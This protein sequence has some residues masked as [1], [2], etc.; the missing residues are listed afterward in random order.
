M[1]LK[2]AIGFGVLVLG[3]VFCAAEVAQAAQSLLAQDAATASIFSHVVG[4]FFMQQRAFHRGL[5]RALS[6]LNGAGDVR[7]GLWLIAVGFVYG[8]FHAAGPGHGKAVLSA[9]LLTNRVHLRRGAVLAVAA[10][11]CQGLSA[12]SIVYGLVWLAGWRSSETMS[13]VSWSERLSYTLLAA[14]GAFWTFRAGRGL[15][16][17]LRPAE[18][19]R[20]GDRE[21]HDHGHMHDRHEHD[22]AHGCGCCHAPSAAQVE[23]AGSLRAAVVLILSIGLRPC[24]G[25]VLILVFAYAAHIPWAGVSAVI[26]MSSGTALTVCTLAVLAVKAR[27]WADALA[28]E[29][30]HPFLP[31]A[32]D[33]FALCCGVLVFA[34]GA[35]MLAGSFAPRLSSGIL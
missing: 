8:V 14:M 23:G 35:S 28:G 21:E 6:L 7:A 29:R 32:M 24:S 3:L 34:L 9:Y 27:D 11:F 17:H 20:H 26:A 16:T 18:K 2:R 5:I 4:W 13:A 10:A 22:H 12:V 1:S 31:L 19:H 33:V 30:R 25:A 15:F